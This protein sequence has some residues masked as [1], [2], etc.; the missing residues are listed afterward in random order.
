[1]TALLAFLAS[2]LLIAA[3][4]LSRRRSHARATVELDLHVAEDRTPAGLKAMSSRI[5]APAV[6][7]LRVPPPH[8]LGRRRLGE[9]IAV[10]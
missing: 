2:T 3:G 4:L 6:T 10:R 1:M 8:A 5:R 7:G 9:W